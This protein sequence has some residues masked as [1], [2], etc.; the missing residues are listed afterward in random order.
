MASTK[1][2]TFNYPVKKPVIPER[3]TRW[4]NGKIPRLRLRKTQTG[5]IMFKPAAKACDLMWAEAKADGI[6]LE[7][8][9]GGYRDYARQEALWYDRMTMKREEAKQPLVRRVWN[10]KVW[11]L[12]KMAPVA[13]PGTSNHGWGL[14]V[15]FNVSDPKVYAWLD[16]NGPRFGFYMEAKPTRHDSEKNPYFEPWHW[17]KVDVS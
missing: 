7:A 3:L 17:T 5:A 4:G 2:P 16:K 1:K 12:K 8:L 11:W 10:G 9:G 13:T 15:D 14:S 6:N